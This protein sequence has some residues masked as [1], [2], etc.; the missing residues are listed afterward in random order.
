MFKII[1]ILLLFQDHDNQSIFV[2]AIMNINK[3]NH[4]EIKINLRS[5]KIRLMLFE[6]WIKFQINKVLM[7]DIHKI[8]EL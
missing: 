2:K 6:D 4:K 5:S 1:L 3:T 7:M 8:F